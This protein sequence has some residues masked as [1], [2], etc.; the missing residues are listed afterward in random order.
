MLVESWPLSTDMWDGECLA[1][2]LPTL[3]ATDPVLAMDNFNK[4]LA[5]AHWDLAKLYKV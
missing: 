3:F 4:D 5:K 1:G 2:P